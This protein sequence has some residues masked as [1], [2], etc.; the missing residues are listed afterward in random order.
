MPLEQ[1]MRPPIINPIPIY[2]GLLALA[3]EAERQ[4]IL[5][6]GP[7]EWLDNNLVFGAPADHE[8][9][10]AAYDAIK[11]ILSRITSG[12]QFCV[13]GID[14]RGIPPTRT[15]LEPSLVLHGRLLWEGPGGCMSKLLV[16]FLEATLHIGDLRIEPLVYRL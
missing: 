12:D 1:V 8:A 2:E 14:P 11:A 6:S 4:V 10:A 3:T 7:R 9:A 5:A 16:M 15:P 13:T